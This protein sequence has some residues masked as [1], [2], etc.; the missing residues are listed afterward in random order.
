MMQK[1]P[2]VE[3]V[4]A[5]LPQVQAAVKREIAARIAAG[6]DIAALDLKKRADKPGRQRAAQ[7]DRVA[8][9]KSAA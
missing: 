6:E 1:R 9:R 8:K 4:L 2:T 3:N 7:G 5:A